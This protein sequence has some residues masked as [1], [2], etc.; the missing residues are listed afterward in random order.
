MMLSIAITL[1]LIRF[2]ATDRAACMNIT[3]IT[4]PPTGIIIHHYHNSGLEASAIQI[5]APPRA[6]HIRKPIQKPILQQAQKYSPSDSEA[7]S[8]ALLQILPIGLDSPSK[9]SSH[10]RSPM[11]SHSCQDHTGTPVCSHPLQGHIN[12]NS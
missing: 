9:I 1:A 6:N 4:N 5:V 12:T 11:C 8:L 7:H 2:P 10:H 3:N